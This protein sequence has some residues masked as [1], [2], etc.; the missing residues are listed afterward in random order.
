VGHSPSLG[1]CSLPA[2]TLPGFLDGRAVGPH[3]SWSR[4]TLSGY[5]RVFVP[6]GNG[7]PSGPPRDNSP[8]FLAPDEKV[9][10]KRRVSVTIGPDG[11]I[12]MADDLSDEIWGVTGAR[13]GRTDASDLVDPSQRETIDALR[14][15]NLRM[16]SRLTRSGTPH[17][18]R[19]GKPVKS[20]PT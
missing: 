12:R 9:S 13:L 17:A 11:S 6:F 16:R 2:D 1:V 15:A 8:G 4:S 20:S 10:Y 5:K 19:P 18:R 3:G 7:H 14:I